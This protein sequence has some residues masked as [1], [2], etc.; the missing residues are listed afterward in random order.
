LYDFKP[1]KASNQRGRGGIETDGQTSGRKQVAEFNRG[2][3]KSKPT[4]PE[5]LARGPTGN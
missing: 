3:A 1:L 2:H 4:L 5:V